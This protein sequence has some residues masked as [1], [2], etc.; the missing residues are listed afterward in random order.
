MSQ[1][2]SPTERVA[3]RVRHETKRRLLQVRH[4]SRITPKMVRIVLG[5]EELGGFVSAAHDDHVKLFFPPLGEDK[6]VFPTQG[7]NGP[8]YPEGTL[9]SAARDYTPRRYD[10]GANTLTIDFAMHGDGPATAWAAQARPGNFLGVGGPSDAAS[11][12]CP[13]VRT[14]S[15]LS[16]LQTAV[17]SNASTRGP[18]WRRIGCFATAPRQAIRRC[19]KMGSLRCGFPPARHM[20]G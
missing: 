1:I 11:K 5:G 14:P 10:A 3:R 4:V 20:R 18:G 13:R 12:N 8:E 6:P 19:C 17:K 2:S 7:A 15:S 16:M 9:P